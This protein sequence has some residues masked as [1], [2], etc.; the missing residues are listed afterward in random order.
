MKV[1]D[2][3]KLTNT[4]LTGEQ[5]VYQKL[6]PFY[7]AVIDDIN[8]RL[9][10][11][12]PSFSSMNYATLDDAV[13]DFFPDRYIRSVVALGAAHKFYTMDEEGVIYDE[14]YSRSYEEAL[15]YM[16]RDYID[17]VPEMFQ[18]DSSGSVPIK[19]FP[20]DEL[21]ICTCFWR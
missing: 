10:S 12:Y 19:D 5:L 15:F 4:Y 8:N 13:Y 21:P 6:L 16:T 3:V 9:N 7:D 11:T 14:E 2:I 18:S 17:Q 1:R 20:Y